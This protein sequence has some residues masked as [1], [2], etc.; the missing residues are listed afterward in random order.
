MNAAFPGLSFCS[1]APMRWLRTT[2][3]VTRPVPPP[4]LSLSLISPRT[5]RPSSNL[6][7]VTGMS[8]LKRHQNTL[9][10]RPPVHRD[11]Y[12]QT[13]DPDA[14]KKRISVLAVSVPAEKASLFIK[15]QELKGYARELLAPTTG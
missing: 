11:M 5:T 6:R 9:D 8:S 7:V 15:S 12:R 13:L 1:V 10:T 4:H 2:R 3:L 14:F